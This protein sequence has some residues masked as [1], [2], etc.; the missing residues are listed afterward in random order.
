[1]SWK[2]Y[3]DR[4]LRSRSKEVFVI[5]EGGKYLS[6]VHFTQTNNPVEETDIKPALAGSYESVDNILQ[7]IV[8]A[9]WEDGIRPK[10]YEDHEGELKATKYHAECERKDL[11]LETRLIKHEIKYEYKEQL[12]SVHEYV[13]GDEGDYPS[14]R[15]PEEI[16]NGDVQEG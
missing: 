5:D 10:G 11:C 4:T 3:I 7:A 9:A 12:V 8:D 2:C 14:N 1:M 13:G 16:K 15:P 6:C